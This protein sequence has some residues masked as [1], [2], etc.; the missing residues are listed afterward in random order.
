MS[1]LN[2][3]KI[4]EDLAREKNIKLNDFVLGRVNKIQ[5][6]A[7]SMT[8]QQIV[9]ALSREEKFFLALDRNDWKKLEDII[10]RAK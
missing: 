7:K 8:P 10:K 5:Q 1:N 9:E 3:K 6:N 4:V 2:L